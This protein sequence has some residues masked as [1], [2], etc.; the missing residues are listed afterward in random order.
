MATEVKLWEVQGTRL[1]KLQEASFSAEHLED[2]LETWIAETPDVLGENLLIIDRQRD[3]P[4]VGRLDLLAIDGDGKFVII[5]LKRDRTPRDAVAQALHYAAWMDT[6][7]EQEVIGFCEEYLKKPLDE[8]FE[9]H[10][11]SPFPSIVCQNHRIILAAPKLDS[12]AELIINYLAERHGVEI[13][14]IFFTYSKV[15]DREVLA[16]AFLVAEETGH[17]RSKR[18]APSVP[19]LLAVAK[20]KGVSGLVEISRHINQ[21]WEERPSTTYGGA[22][23]RYWGRTGGGK[24]RMV[25]GLNIAGGRAHPPTGQLDVWIISEN[26]SEVSGINEATIRQT[27]SD[28]HPLHQA[29]AYDCL[30]RLETASE[31]EALVSQLRDWADQ[32]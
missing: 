18:K 3:L 17:D 15:G 19:E 27:L 14:A 9:E 1:Q 13:N 26:L 20:E 30:I 4:T 6:A 25:F 28:K 8:A 11:G 12:G 7:T 16:R 31:A 32:K 10:F 21:V 22:S 23:F 2:E 5:E 29:N 24:L